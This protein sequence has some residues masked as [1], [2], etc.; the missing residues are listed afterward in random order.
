MSSCCFSRGPLN[1]GV[2][3]NV[4]HDSGESED[5]TG[6]RADQEDGGN[7]ELT[8]LIHVN[9]DYSRSGRKPYRRC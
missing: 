8:G 1:A 9:V 5:Q 3:H 2:T 6:S 4:L 7:L